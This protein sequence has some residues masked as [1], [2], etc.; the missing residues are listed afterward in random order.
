VSTAAV[1][2]GAIITIIFFSAVV[3]IGGGAAAID[4]AFLRL[5]GGHF[6]L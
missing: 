6:V 3:V 5:L 1:A 2:I 4:D